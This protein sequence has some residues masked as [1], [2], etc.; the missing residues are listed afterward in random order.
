MSADVLL[1]I[2]TEEIPAA[3][4]AR[5]LGELEQRASAAL[6]EARLAVASVRALGTPRRLVLALSG[7]ADRQPDLE[8]RVVGPPA[9]VG[10]GDDG[11]PTKAAV[12]FAKRNGVDV[13]DLE[14]AEVDGKKGE[15]VVC[16]RREL[17]QPAEAVLSGLLDD[18]IAALPWPKSMRW[19]QREEAFV[20]PVHWIVALLGDEVLPVSFAGVT[21]GATSRGHRF[22]AP[23]PFPV[24]S[25]LGGY[26][27]ALRERFVIVDPAV[28]REMIAA[29]IT[30]VEAEAGAQV[31][32]DAAL[33]AEVANLVEYPSAICGS[34]DDAFLEV[35]E[36]V[37]VSAMRSHQRYF[38][39]EGQDGR[40]VSRFLTIAGTVTRDPAVVRAGNERV[41]AARLSDA[42]FFFR[43]DRKRPLAEFA[44]RLDQVVF[45]AKLGSIGAKVERV[46]ALAV[47]LAGEVGADPDHT[48]RAA[49]LCKAD[50]VTQ[51]VYEFPDL[52][53][54]MGRHYARLSGEPEPVCE[55]IYEHYLPRGAGDALPEHAI[56]AA[57][58]L[59]D[60]LDTLVGCFAV[61]LAPSGSADPYGLRRAAVGILTLL[62]ARGWSV[63]LPSLVERAGAGLQDRVAVS[64]ECRAQVLGFLRTRLKGLL[65]QLPADCV[66]AAL[67]AGY[68]DVPDAC[69][70]AEAVAALRERDDFEPI[71]VAFKRVANILKGAAVAPDPDPGRFCEAAEEALWGAFGPIERQVTAHLGERAYGAALAALAELRA[72]V[73]RFFDEV[74]VMDKD[75][76]IRENRLALLARIG[77][78]FARIADF[79]QLAV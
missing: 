56:G 76:E 71:G 53:G 23:E 11:Q 17:G 72:P 14:R 21:A 4:L 42:R 7:V 25:D 74:L 24:T 65:G 60:R 48:E 54:V 26:L 37:I 75:P 68:D 5:A 77:T 31:R 18:L 46:A 57:L 40:L 8:L 35:P 49:K 63:S 62:S 58:G 33:I 6:A 44:P 39:L 69:A 55:A 34:F 70:R 28:R 61:G 59:A 13:A 45:Q 1:E 19:G 43:E 22:L 20:R 10:F 29:E 41:L 67:T 38:A 2:G 66:E 12:G 32:E 50:L 15:Y 3:L 78:A 9:R 36:E 64:D 27:Q 47:S 30:R 16:T 52:Q 73:D 51:M 79:R